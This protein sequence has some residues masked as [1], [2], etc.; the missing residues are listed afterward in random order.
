MKNKLL[1]GST[2][3]F[4]ICFVVSF[5]VAVWTLLDVPQPPDVK[6]EPVEINFGDVAAS[7]VQTGEFVLT[8]HGRSPIFIRDVE[9]GCGCTRVDFRKGRLEPKEKTRFF[10]KLNPY[11]Y[12]GE[13]TSGVVVKLVDPYYENSKPLGVPVSLRATVIPAPSPSEETAPPLLAP[14]PPP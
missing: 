11:G 13:V 6:V 12:K 14:P 9:V 1:L 2:I 3:A 7:E 10:V 4:F 8:N 5:F